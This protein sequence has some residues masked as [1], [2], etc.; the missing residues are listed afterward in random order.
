MREP[1]RCTKDVNKPL[2][3]S[4]PYSGAL[5]SGGLV[6]TFLTGAAM[7]AALVALT[8]PKSGPEHRGDL[9]NMAQRAQ[10]KAGFLAE[11]AVEAWNDLNEGVVLA[12]AN[13]E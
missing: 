11:E 1:H 8:T 10:Q 9:K 3:A 12:A 4:E 6:L 2:A 5:S 7:G 13:F